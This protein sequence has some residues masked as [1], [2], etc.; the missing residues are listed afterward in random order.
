M[1]QLLFAVAAEESEHQTNQLELVLFQLLPRMLVKP[2]KT[3]PHNKEAEEALF[4]LQ[5]FSAIPQH[6]ILER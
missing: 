4:K 3:I 5:A 2:T 1:S 6:N